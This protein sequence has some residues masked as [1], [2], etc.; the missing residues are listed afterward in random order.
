MDSNH[1]ASKAEDQPVGSV[2]WNEVQEVIEKLNEQEKANYRPQNVGGKI[3]NPWGLYNMH[4]NVMGYVEDSCVDGYQT[5]YEDGRAIEKGEGTLR[6]V[7]G[8][9]WTNF[10]KA[11]ESAIP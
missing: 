9:T 2:S 4:G 5:S 7:R 8:G 11:L 1:S 10:E 3:A 6:V